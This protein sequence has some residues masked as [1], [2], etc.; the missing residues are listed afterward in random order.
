MTNIPASKDYQIEE[1]RLE[2]MK[3][4]L[5]DGAGY[6]YDEADRLVS[7]G[8]TYDEIMNEVSLVRTISEPVKRPT[9][10]AQIIKERLQEKEGEKN[11]PST[12]YKSL[13]LL[14]KGFIPG[15]LYTFTGETNV[16][17]TSIAC[18]FA[19]RMAMQGDR[20][21]LYF[22]LE[23]DRGVADYLASIASQKRFDDLYP[24]DYELIP[25]G[26]DVFTK[27]VVRTMPDLVKVVMGGDRYDL[28]IVDHIGYF[29]K[30]EASNLYQEQAN[31]IKELVGL[32]KKKRCAIM[33]I[34]HLNKQVKGTPTM[35]DISGSGAF[36]QDSTE[37]LIA[38]RDKSAQDQFELTYQNTGYLLVAKTK[39]GK[40]GAI[41]ITYTDGGGEVTEPYIPNLKELSVHEQ[42]SIFIGGK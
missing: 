9:N 35:N 3:Q 27:D 1:F 33:L 40:S 13:D 2:M 32:A 26:I 23:P 12:G 38:I 29:V 24:E 22:A 30:P 36:K 16:G 19:Y 14:I 10:I 8:Y 7:T 6:S 17:K 4:K 42:E 39:S 5:M 25:P 41:K 21:I 28:I 37:V 20:R 15:H 31:V 18:N 34:A 11:A